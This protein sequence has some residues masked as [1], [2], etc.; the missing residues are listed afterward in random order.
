MEH[1]TIEQYLF[2]QR[3]TAS[4]LKHN[5]DKNWKRN[6]V[7]RLVLSVSKFKEKYQ[8]LHTLFANSLPFCNILSQREMTNPICVVSSSVSF[9]KPSP[10]YPNLYPDGRGDFL[11]FSFEINEMGFFSLQLLPL[12]SGPLLHPL[13]PLGSCLVFIQF[14]FSFFRVRQCLLLGC[15]FFSQVSVWVCVLFSC[16]LNPFSCFLLPFLLVSD[17]SFLF[18]CGILVIKIWL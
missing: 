8:F 12:S 1:Y 13:F 18:G 6:L 5:L 14:V 9:C 7:L 3:E 16:Y 2:L 15:V 4:F 11:F 10:P 17:W